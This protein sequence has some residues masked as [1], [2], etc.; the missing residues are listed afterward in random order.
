MAY[1]P[2]PQ[3]PG[4]NGL[5]F[6]LTNCDSDEDDFLPGTIH[7]HDNWMRALTELNFDVR[8]ERNLDEKLMKDF[9]ATARGT[10]FTCKY[11][12]FVFSG[13]GEE[14]SLYSQDGEK[15]S[16]KEDIF[17][18]FFNGTMFTA[19]KLFFL[20]ACRKKNGKNDL[21]CNESL[22]P[23]WQD[24]SGRYFAF[25]PVALGQEASDYNEGSP[26]SKAITSAIVKDI[27]L[28]DVVAS[29]RAEL[30]KKSKSE[31]RQS[32][33]QPVSDILEEE[34]YL[35]RFQLKG[36]FANGIHRQP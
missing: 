19:H 32:V 9:L 35:A 36:V 29:T 10:E 28:S 6:L 23:D 13:H 3:K 7:D 5:A 17:P 4:T 11:V 34:V 25:Y 12:I 27:S 31:Y 18:N 1:K 22:F 14:D 20:D 26:F 8:W 24:G 30:S 16:L 21:R 2:R 15:V 33:P